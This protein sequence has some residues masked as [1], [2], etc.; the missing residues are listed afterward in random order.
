MRMSRR[1][2]NKIFNKISEKDFELFKTNT[3]NKSSLSDE[4]KKERKIYLEKIRL[5][6]DFMNELSK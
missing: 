1:E 3:L 2:L 4:F 5:V 6:L